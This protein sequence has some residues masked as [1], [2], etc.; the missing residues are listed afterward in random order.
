MSY[1]VFLLPIVVAPGT[2]R[3]TETI[4]GVP[5]P[6]TLTIIDPA[7]PGLTTPLSVSKTFYMRGDG[8]ATDLLQLLKLTLDTHTGANV[9]TVAISRNIDGTLLPSSVT[10]SAATNNF[11]IDWTSV[12]TT[13]N[14]R[15]FGFRSIATTSGLTTTGDVSPTSQWV[16]NDV[17]EFFEEE[18]EVAAFVERARSGA[19]LGGRRGGPYDIRR[20]GLRF[21]AEQRTVVK[22]VPTIS[23][24]LDTG[25]AFASTWALMATGRAF[26]VHLASLSAGS[27]LAALSTT[28][29]QA[30]LQ[31]TG[32]AW[33]L[34]SDTIENGFS[35]ERLA[36]GVGL[37]AWSMRMLGNVP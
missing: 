29:R 34:D 6:Q 12:S 5:T 3:L 32:T 27:T 13:L 23:T 36:P 15:H 20:M 16:A 11:S 9:Y 1:P 2:V 31:G 14:E 25:R 26:E 37:Y 35:P 17:V 7:G 19:V 18:D 10:I 24:V 8:S 4:A 30:C 22:G 21:Q 28:T 33:H